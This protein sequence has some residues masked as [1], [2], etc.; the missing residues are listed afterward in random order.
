MYNKKKL[1]QSKWKE[2][3]ISKINNEFIQKSKKISEWI[4][5]INVNYKNKNELLFTYNIYRRDFLNCKVKLF[6][7]YPYTNE[8]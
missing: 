4:E 7:F 1:Y 3:I 6:T 2:S 5:F 8:E